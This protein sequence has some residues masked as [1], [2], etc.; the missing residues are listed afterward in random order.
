[1]CVATWTLETMNLFFALFKM[2][3]HVEWLLATLAYLFH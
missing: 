1:M 3:L 2:G